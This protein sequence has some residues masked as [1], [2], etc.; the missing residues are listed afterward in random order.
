[1]GL[2][3]HDRLDHK[4]AQSTRLLALERL[5]H[6]GVGGFCLLGLRGFWYAPELLWC[7]IVSSRCCC[8][9]I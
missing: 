8:R 1:M 9:R 5:S 7:V 2:E 4:H 6:K 3:T